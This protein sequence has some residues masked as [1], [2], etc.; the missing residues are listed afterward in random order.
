MKLT[1]TL[2]LFPVC[3]I[4]IN[5]D[6]G[7]WPGG[8]GAFLSSRDSNLPISIHYRVP[9][10]YRPISY[11]HVPKNK[12]FPIARIDIS[13]VV[14]KRGVDLDGKLYRDL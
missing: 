2:E 13:I 12:A 9:T 1:L 10:P 11:C 14:I 6:T 4:I 7:G 5:V 8:G 3:C